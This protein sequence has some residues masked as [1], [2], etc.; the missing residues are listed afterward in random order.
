MKL[1]ASQ[2]L[3]R[4]G[5]DGKPVEIAKG[6]TFEVA[7]TTEAKRLVNAGL[8]TRADEQPAKAAPAPAPKAGGFIE[9][10]A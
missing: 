8:A 2:A 1:I 6:A 3:P 10:K 5:D 4:L 9:P 7:D